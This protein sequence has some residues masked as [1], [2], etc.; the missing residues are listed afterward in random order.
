MNFIYFIIFLNIF[1][2]L[3]LF[4][5]HTCR[6]RTPGRGRCRTPGRRGGCGSPGALGCPR[7]SWRWAGS[8]R[9]PCC[10]W[11]ASGRRPRGRAC[12]SHSRRRP[13]TRLRTHSRGRSRAET[14]RIPW[15]F[16]MHSRGFGLILPWK[17]GMSFQEFECG[18]WNFQVIWNWMVQGNLEL[19][20]GN[21]GF[22]GN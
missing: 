7:G 5:A 2:L 15:E 12:G 22:P 10:S 19:F 3:Y 17:F 13:P 20:S 21:M 1:I 6:W 8:P 18:I 9:W 11:W 4:H 14:L 16:G